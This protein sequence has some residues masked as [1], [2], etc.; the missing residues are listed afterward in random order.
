MLA[1]S[2]QDGFVRL[3]KISPRTSSQ[4][5]Y[6]QVADL[7]PG[8]QIKIEEKIFSVKSKNSETHSFATSLESVLHGHDGWVYGVHWN[9]L[10]NGSLQ[11]LSS[12]IDKTLILWMAQEDSGVWLEKVRVGDVGGNSLGFFGGKISATGKSILGHGYQGSLHM[13]HQDEANPGLWAPGVVVGGHFDEVRDLAWE[14]NGQYLMSLSADQT[15]R[16]HV[17]WNRPNVETTVNFF[18]SH[19]LN[20]NF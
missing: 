14:P 18:F 2:S 3:W 12:S 5:K 8:E 7:L 6:K 11:L 13:W 20:L 16:I 1:S 4:D 17:P 10:N 19:I 15:T 9:K